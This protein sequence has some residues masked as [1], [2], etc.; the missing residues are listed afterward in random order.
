MNNENKSKQ[1]DIDALLLQLRLFSEPQS[2]LNLPK[3]FV[4]NRVS[5]LKV[6]KF[7]KKYE[8]SLVCRVF[9]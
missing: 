2:T 5:S 8:S 3:P 9:L 6:T 7:L 4:M 1:V